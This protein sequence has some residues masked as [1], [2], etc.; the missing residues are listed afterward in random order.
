[1]KTSTK[2]YLLLSGILVVLIGFLFRE[3]FLGMVLQGVDDNVSMRQVLIRSL[4][5]GQGYHFISNYW[6]GFIFNVPN[7]DF[8]NTILALTGNVRVAGV[9]FLALFLSGM[10]TFK[11]IKRLDVSDGASIFGAISYTFLPHVLSL[12]YSGHALA[13][14][15]IPM[16]PGFLLCLSVILDGRTNALLFKLLAGAWGGIFW[17]WMMIGEPQRGIY[18]TVLGMAWV[19]FLL[20]QDK[21]VSFLPRPQINLSLLKKH[22]PFLAIIMIVGLGIFLSTIKFWANSEFLANKGSWDFATSWSFPPSELIDTLAFGYHGLSSSDPNALYWGDKPLSG[23]TDSLGFFM[24]IFMLLGAIFAWKTQKKGLRFFIIAGVIAMLLSFGKYM[25]GKP[26]FW[27]WYHLPG[28]DKLRVPAKFLSITGLTWSIA[29]AMGLDSIQSIFN[30][31]D[32]KK[33]HTLLIVVG[34]FFGLS[35]LWALSLLMNN[36]GDPS[37]IRPIL[38]AKFGDSVNRQIINAVLEG[39][40][41][42]I[43][44]M[45]IMSGLLFLVFGMMYK[46]P[47][48]RPFFPLMI[49]LLTMINVYQSNRYYIAL[50]YINEEQAYQKTETVNFLKQHLTQS[51]RASG[52]LFLPNTTGSPSA[53][54][55]VVEQQL[56][57][58]NNTDLTYAFPYHDINMFGRIPVSR[59]DDGYYRFFKSAYDSVSF[60][61]HNN[62]IW[63]M[64]KRL[65]YLGNVKYLILSPE[66]VNI[67]ATNLEADAVFITNTLG[68]GNQ[69][70]MIYEL[71]KTLPRF[72][73]VDRVRYTYDL[74][75]FDELTKSLQNLNQFAI[76]LEDTGV[77]LSNKNT[78]DPRPVSVNR[79]EYNSYEIALDNL[80]DEILYFGDLYDEGWHVAIDGEDTPIY[81]A[82][83]IQQY[84]IV[85]AGSK[86]LKWYY[87][88][89]VEGLL[90]SRIFILLA[91]LWALGMFLKEIILKK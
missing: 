4:L 50:T 63:E 91:F 41:S 27:L 22:L 51:Y 30:N 39:K 12:V 1:M 57:S 3:T 80:E 83:G 78:R 16:T 86:V 26:F 89:P 40:L 54:G 2:Y 25:P 56:Y 49:I 7:P 58:A 34:S 77:V 44:D 29:A 81:K 18:G 70:N 6:L 67:F 48:L 61:Q 37:S 71:K 17:A 65:W 32:K 45:M 68:T 59:I 69:T 60:Y 38:N 53:I 28:M 42:A 36:G 55:T 9:Y 75:L 64:N 33:K 24:F 73:F 62:D 31:D 19:I 8:Y 21:S 14:E 13:L 5:S 85:P 76:P 88:R 35:L 15:A 74:Y 90:F 23:N 52:S 84:V 82:N 79:V 47:R 10:M 20:N 11:L 43:I 87:N 46:I 72:A 66:I